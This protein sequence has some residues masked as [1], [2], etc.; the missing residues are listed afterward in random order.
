MKSNHLE[1]LQG[2]AVDVTAALNEAPFEHEDAIYRGLREALYSF[3]LRE[4]EEDMSSID[5]L[6]YIVACDLQGSGR[7]AETFRKVARE[8]CARAKETVLS[9][10]YAARFSAR[11]A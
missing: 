10:P 4:F 6:E 9:R 7:R 8:E 11:L 1:L 3:F 2:L 5:A